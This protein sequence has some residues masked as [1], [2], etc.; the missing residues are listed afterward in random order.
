M[1]LATG[2][3]FDSTDSQLINRSGKPATSDL[4][5]L[6]GYLDG[7][8]TNGKVTYLVGHTYRTAGNA[9]LPISSN[10]Q[11]NGIRL[12]LDGLFVSP[13]TSAEGLSPARPGCSFMSL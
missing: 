11:T 9:K 7:A 6:T 8:S 5:L 10:P 12:Y 1:N 4:A 3:A 13:C 2:S